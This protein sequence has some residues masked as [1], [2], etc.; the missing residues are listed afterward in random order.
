MNGINNQF[1][2][3][4]RKKEQLKLK[5]NHCFHLKQTV[6]GMLAHMK[7]FLKIDIQDCNS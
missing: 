1:Y 3:D 6:N 7:F 2:E 5:I 4:S